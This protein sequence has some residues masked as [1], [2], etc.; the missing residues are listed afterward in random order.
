[1]V[2]TK[3]LTW[4][5]DYCGSTDI[6]YNL[7]ILGKGAITSF[8]PIQTGW[9]ITKGIMIYSTYFRL[10]SLNYA[11]FFKNN[12]NNFNII[13]YFFDWGK[14]SYSLTIQLFNDSVQ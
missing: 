13:K 1:M 12:F 10:F 5:A 11:M 9:Y 3:D 6:W 8:C 7:G 4:S 2:D 14:Y